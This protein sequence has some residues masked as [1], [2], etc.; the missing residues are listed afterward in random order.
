MDPNWVL[1]WMVTV[2]TGLFVVRQGN[3]AAS[4]AAG[5]WVVCGLVFAVLGL[6]LWQD[7]AHA[8]YW[9]AAVWGPFL[10]VPL[11]ALGWHKS[12][13]DRQK[14]RAAKWVTR[15]I[16]LLHPCDGW[17]DAPGVFQA[18]EDFQA[19][20]VDDCLA[21]L[22]R[23]R[24]QDHVFGWAANLHWLRLRGDWTGLRSW[25]ESRLMGRRSPFY[26]GNLLPYLRALG[27]LGELEALLRAAQPYAQ[28]LARLGV[29][30]PYQSLRLHVLAYCG[31]TTAVQALF[32][33]PLTKTDYPTRQFWL[34]TSE[35]AAGDFAA[36]EARVRA[37]LAQANPGQRLGLEQRLAA[38][39][40]SS[41]ARHKLSKEALE[42]LEDF[43]NPPRGTMPGGGLRE[44][45]TGTR[46][47]T[48]AVCA[49]LIGVYALE[50]RSD[51]ESQD[52][53]LGL[54]NLGALII[55]PEFPEDA[56][57][58][59]AAGLLHFGALHLC[60]NLGGL[61]LFGRFVERR[62]GP[63]HFLVAY[64]VTGI[65]ALLTVIVREMFR[66]GPGESHSILVGSSGNVMGLYGI[67]LGLLV[68]QGWRDRSI[69]ARQDFFLLLTL[70][71]LQVGFDWVTPQISGTAHLGGLLLGVLW[72]LSVGLWP[73]RVPEERVAVT[74]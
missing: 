6:A 18:L 44:P 30:E 41:V 66:S 57:R 23:I 35:L 59:F 19:G 58:L 45:S 9:A 8:G 16:A 48:P 29:A 43:V 34:A 7:R 50:P 5:W 74:K 42:I 60:L 72:G 69:G 28:Q 49:L 53:I 46:W 63:W 2:S 22:D 38:P 62:L 54:R 12:L 64:F 65:G 71:I 73:R 26:Q 25:Y 11:L 52:Y 36:G 15:L 24:K 33:G 13:A 32:A 61:W 10:V 4:R 1:L 21:R 14:F 56:W 67:S 27:E 68:C 31:Q 70:L 37:A 40:R 47:A 20:R 55:P 39:P 51:L 17:L 3:L